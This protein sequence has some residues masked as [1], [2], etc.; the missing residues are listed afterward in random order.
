[1]LMQWTYKYNKGIYALNRGLVKIEDE[2]TE[3]KKF[4]MKKID[5]QSIWAN[6]VRGA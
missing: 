1:M 4:L 3:L 5:L 6:K 2:L